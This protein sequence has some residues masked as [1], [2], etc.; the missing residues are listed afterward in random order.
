MKAQL[1]RVLAQPDSD[2]ERLVYA[3]MLLER[4]DIRGEFIVLQMQKKSTYPQ[5]ARM[6]KILREHSDAF[7]APLEG[8]VS[9][10]GRE[11]ARGFLSRCM[12]RE[13]REDEL[14]RL[15]NDRMWATVDEVHGPAIIYRSPALVSLKSVFASQSD[16][17]LTVLLGPP[18]ERIEVFRC[19]SP[20]DG[21]EHHEALASCPALPKVAVLYLNLPTDA[22]VPTILQ[23]SVFRRLKLLDVH[24][25]Q[26]SAV[27][28]PQRW[29]ERLQGSASGPAKVVF[30]LNFE[31]TRPSKA[32][33]T[34]ERGPDGHYQISEPPYSE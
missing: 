16:D 30:H 33:V 31:Y 32:T 23:G 34:L 18:C 29:L 21:A 8:I 1:E 6:R 10:I 19:T 22:A 28:A 13:Y 15:A 27:L 5:E 20:G 9:K 14:R 26:P 25:K 4:G 7:V 3:D 12:I 11:F 2:D 17:L 24:V